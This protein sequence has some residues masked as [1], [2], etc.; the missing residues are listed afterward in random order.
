MER[1]TAR[2]MVCQVKRRQTPID[3]G[4]VLKVRIKVCTVHQVLQQQDIIKYLTDYYG[5]WTRNPE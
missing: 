1:W 3:I 2:G 4:T 5:P